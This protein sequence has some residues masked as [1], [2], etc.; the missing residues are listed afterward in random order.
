VEEGSSL[1]LG[2]KAEQTGI[3]LCCDISTTSAVTSTFK[4]IAMASHLMQMAGKRVGIA[5]NPDEQ[6]AASGCTD[7][8]CGLVVSVVL[9]ANMIHFTINVGEG[10]RALQVVAA[11]GFASWC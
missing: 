10:G 5:G 1:G 2:T 7:A 6:A 11:K 9:E 8:R 3:L 4:K